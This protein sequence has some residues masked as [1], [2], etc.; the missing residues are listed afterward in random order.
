[1]H[2]AAVAV[3]P[4]GRRVGRAIGDGANPKR[5]G[6]AASAD[7][8][9]ALA[10]AAA[11]D[12]PVALLL[13]AGAGIDRPENAA[14]LRA[15][16]V[17]RASAGRIIVVNDTLAALRAG[18]PDAVGLVVVAGTGGNVLGRGPDGRVSN[19]GHGVF[20]GSYVLAA[21]A[22]RAAARR[23]PRVG[24]AVGRAFAAV[25][26][27]AGGGGRPLRPGPEVAALAPALLAAG[28]AGDALVARIVDRWC[29]HVTDAVRD[30]VTRLGLGPE[31]VVVLYGGL[32]DASP[33]LEGRLREA[34][35]EGAPGARIARL[36]VGPV[37][38]AALLA[39]DAWAGRPVRWEFVP[40]R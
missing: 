18:T 10:A 38:G 5:Q 2:S 13:V 17:T 7:G 4:D 16:L 22:L 11:G 1:M 37:E 19:R 21:L 6:L 39:R 24:A 33:W 20:G 29:A 15:A 40:R 31:P 14:T 25:T 36:A 12:R 35:L 27:A 8:I 23:D 26:P 30:E 3:T 32:L 28:A 9:A 34:V